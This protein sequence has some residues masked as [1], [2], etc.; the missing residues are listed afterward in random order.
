MPTKR[1]V[2]ASDIVRDIRFGHTNEELMEKYRF[3]RAGL[4]SVFK[5]LV[6]LRAVSRSEL[7]GRI[8]SQT[9]G[10]S[11]DEIRVQ[12]LRKAPR[13]LAL[14]PIPI[15]DGK[16]PKISGMLKDITQDG[17]GITEIETRVGETRTFVILGDEFVAVEFETFAFDAVCRWIKTSDEEEGY[18]AGFEITSISPRDGDQLGKL[19]QSLTFYTPEK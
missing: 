5:Q 7:Y 11:E 8:P 12:S 16:N 17:V 2:K 15:Y 13:H 3:T 6:D 14:F 4:Q 10:P 1:M 18:A 9:E 19:L